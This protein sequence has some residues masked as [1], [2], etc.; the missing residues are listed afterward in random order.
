M[1]STL[2]FNSSKNIN[3]LIRSYSTINSFVKLKE[4]LHSFFPNHD[5]S[6]HTKYHL[7]KIFS[8]IM[9]ENAFGET[10]IK[11]LLFNLFDYENAISA[12]EVKTNNSRLDFIRINGFSFSYEIKSELDSLNKLKKQV[13]DYNRLFEYNYVV[14]DTLHYIKCFDII[15]DNYGIYEVV[16]RNLILIKKPIKNN[17]FDSEAQLKLFTKKEFRKFLSPYGNTIEEV[18]K[19]LSPNTINT[20][21]KEMLKARYVDRST[22]LKRH[23]GLILPID[24]Q[25]FFNRNIPPTIIYNN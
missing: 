10:W 24:Y 5:F 17:N 2:H 9:C 8:D 12:F 23:K 20:Q 14:T 4:A 22:F 15:P 16:N 21:F 13:T 3:S 11:Y 19:S 7:H 6:R 18:L 1:D 25:F